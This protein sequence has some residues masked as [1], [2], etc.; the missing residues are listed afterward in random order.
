[1]K[2]KGCIKKFLSTYV[3]LEEYPY[4]VILSYGIFML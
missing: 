4:P 2:F 1:M 3:S